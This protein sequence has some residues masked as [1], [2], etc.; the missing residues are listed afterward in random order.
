MKRRSFRKRAF[1]RSGLISTSYL[2]SMP[3]TTFFANQSDQDLIGLLTSHYLQ[4]SGWLESI[5][6]RQPLRGGK[7]IPWFTYPA[8]EFFDSIVLEGKTVLEVGSGFSTLYWAQ[9]GCRGVSL[10]IDPEWANSLSHTLSEIADSDSISVINVSN[11]LFK[12]GLKARDFLDSQQ[13][14]KLAAIPENEFPEE[15]LIMIENETIIID[16]LAN[17]LPNCDLF[18]VDGIARNLCLMMADKLCKDSVLIVLDNSDRVDYLTGRHFLVSR[19]WEPTIFTGL[20]P[21]NPYQWSTT[22]FR[23]R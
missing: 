23:K 22:V 6:T 17:H 12:P 2:V 14:E 11:S 8:I 15:S 16:S 19:G 1:Q 10:E 5:R 20:G 7:P 9:R 3:K 18:I 4:S 13:I 21:I